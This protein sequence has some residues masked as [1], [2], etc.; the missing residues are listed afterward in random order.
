MAGASEGI[1]R[2]GGLSA[3]ELELNKKCHS[4]RGDV[5]VSSTLSNEATQGLKM[6]VCF[7]D[8]CLVQED[9][10]CDFIK[11]SE[12]FFRPFFSKLRTIPVR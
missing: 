11:H 9:T 3:N 10:N 5:A 8:V 6:C 4:G 12:A 1:Y 2:A 7:S